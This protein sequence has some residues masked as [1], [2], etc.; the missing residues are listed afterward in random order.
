MA[1][2]DYGAPDSEEEGR[3]RSERGD[4]LV[5]HPTTAQCVEG[6]YPRPVNMHASCVVIGYNIFKEAMEQP[7]WLHYHLTVLL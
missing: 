6:Y 4:K 3:R 5:T 2:H 7:R 1:N